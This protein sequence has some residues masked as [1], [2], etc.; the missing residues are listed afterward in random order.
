[1]HVTVVLLAAGSSRRFG[2][3]KM[4][5]DVGGEPLVAR[6]ARVLLEGGADSVVAVLGARADEVGAALVRLTPRIVVNG[7]WEDG[8]FGSVQVGIAA[9]EPDAMRIAV[10]P[11]DL[12]EL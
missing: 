3:P 6:S 7:R 11:A 8:M 4:L 5:A 2:G 9:A 10:T 12:P 1:M